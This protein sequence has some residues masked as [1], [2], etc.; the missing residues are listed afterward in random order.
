MIL[1][2]ISHCIEFCLRNVNNKTCPLCRETLTS[3]D[4][5]W[6]LYDAPNVAEISEEV[7]TTLNNLTGSL[8]TIL[9]SPDSTLGGE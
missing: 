4:D 1:L 9:A 5:T 8:A 6:V 2:N 7:C 3:T